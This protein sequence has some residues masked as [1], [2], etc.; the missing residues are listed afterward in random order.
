MIVTRVRKTAPP[1][2]TNFENRGAAKS[3]DENNL[4]LRGAFRIATTPTIAKNAWAA[5]PMLWH[6][7][8][9]DGAAMLQ[10]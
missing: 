3:E 9:G 6:H 5:V 10:Q 7:R 1:D 2:G 8:A 4:V